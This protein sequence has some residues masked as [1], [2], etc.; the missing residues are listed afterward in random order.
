M[1]FLEDGEWFIVYFMISFV[2]TQHREN[3]AKGFQR[4]VRDLA[5]NISA[6]AYTQSEEAAPCKQQNEE[7]KNANKTLMKVSKQLHACVLNRM[8]LSHK[9]PMRRS[10]KA[11]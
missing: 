7:E 2:C 1:A 11:G 9:S 4:Q 6:E 3:L 10:E 8:S 5:R